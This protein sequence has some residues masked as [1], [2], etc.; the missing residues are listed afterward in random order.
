MRGDDGLAL[1]AASVAASQMRHQ[2]Q[3]Q[4]V[5]GN[6]AD[7]VNALSEAPRIIVVDATHGAGEPGSLSRVEI[8][9]GVLQSMPH[10]T[11]RVSSH[12]LGL[13]EALGLAA[14]LGVAPGKGVFIGMEGASY[15]LGQPMSDAVRSGLPALVATL[16]EE[17]ARLSATKRRVQELAAMG[18]DCGQLQSC[19]AEDLAL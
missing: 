18:I 9:N 12:G 3:L 7:L 8:V 4:C 14:T 15:E 10:D 6:V 17:A 16:V 11:A 19:N 1:E 5:N 13:Q 2:V